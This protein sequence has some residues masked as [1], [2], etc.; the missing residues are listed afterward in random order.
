M[1]EPF[2]SDLAAKVRYSQDLIPCT[3]K[4]IGDELHVSFDCNVEAITAG[5]S[6]VLY[7]GDIVVGGGIIDESM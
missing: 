5:Q 7:S 3:A 4:I 1:Q 2:P 6:V